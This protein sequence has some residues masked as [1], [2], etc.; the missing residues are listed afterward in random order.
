[1]K[2]KEYANEELGVK[3]SLPER[4]TVREVLNL[5]GRVFE[6]ADDGWYIRYWEAVIPLLNDWECKAIPKPDEFD[7]DKSTSLND[8]N[9]VHWT[10][11]TVAAHM[12]ELDDVPKKS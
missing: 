2:N 1:M 9:I 6:N 3:F 11:N 5:R 12:A 8:A 10:A 7:L 4:F